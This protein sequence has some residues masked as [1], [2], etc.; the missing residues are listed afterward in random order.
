MEPELGAE[1]AR[2]PAPPWRSY[3]LLVDPALRRAPQKVYRYDGVH[4]SVPRIFGWTFGCSLC[5][6]QDSGF[7]PRGAPSRTRDPRRIWAKH[8]DLA[9]PVPKFKLDEFYVGPPPLTEVTFARGSTTTCA[10][11]SWPTCAA[12][13]AP[14]TRWRSCCTPAPASTWGWPGVLFASPRA[15]KDSV[16]HLHNTSVMGNVIH[17][18]IDVKGLEIGVTYL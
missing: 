6:V 18:Q 15:A 16:R 8:R 11:P 7:P 3:K 4:F 5:V 2:A 17:A 13:S 10:S 12:S 14:W 1:P 9:L